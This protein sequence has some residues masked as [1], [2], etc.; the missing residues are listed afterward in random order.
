MANITTI[1]L[2]GETKQRLEHLKEHKRE[3]FDEVIKKILYILNQIRKDPVSANRL[4]SRIDR[5]VKRK[6]I[7]SKRELS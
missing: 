6:K 4:L 2:R 3:T 7:Y 5:N 1:K